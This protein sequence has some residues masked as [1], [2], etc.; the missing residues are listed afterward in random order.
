MVSAEG[1]L[2]RCFSLL[3]FPPS[4]KLMTLYI[5]ERE[6]VN[7]KREGRLVKPAFECLVA[8]SFFFASGNII[9]ARR[10]DPQG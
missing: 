6:Y 9:F 8:R 10:R 3:S 5:E 4:V 7:E 2:K 1:L